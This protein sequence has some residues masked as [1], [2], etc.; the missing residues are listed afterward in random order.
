MRNIRL[1]LSYDGTDFH[2]WQ[3]QPGK[4][5]IQEC[6]ES[7]LARLAGAGVKIIGSGRTDAGV[8]ALAQVANFK[9]ASPI[10]CPNL[11]RALNDGLPSTIRITAAEE[12]DA[13]FHARYCARSK[14]YRYRLLEGPVCPPFLSRFV[15]HYPYP[16]DHRRMSRAARMIEGEHDFTS[17][18]AVSGEPPPLPSEA[19]EVSQSRSMVR[20]I[21][22]SRLLV[23]SRKQLLVYEVRGNGFLHHMVRNVLGTLIKVGRGN[24]QPEDMGRILQARDRTMAGP[25]APP[26]GLFLVKVEY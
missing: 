9:T 6:V 12:V 17:F 5:S 1:T 4:A 23:S 11:L 21:D 8:H 15:H 2:G 24:L 19:S 22:S 3:R 13:D 7:A 10:P 20:R 25:T 16:L 26:S 18:A 14:T